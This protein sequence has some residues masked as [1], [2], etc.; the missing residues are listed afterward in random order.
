MDLINGETSPPL[1]SVAIIS[2]PT[3]G[4]SEVL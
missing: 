4:V 3:D 2:S 1:S